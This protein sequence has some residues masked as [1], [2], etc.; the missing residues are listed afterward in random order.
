MDNDGDNDVLV[1][2]DESPSRLW[3]NDG[4]GAFTDSGQSL[5]TGRGYGDAAFSD[6]D[7][8]GDL[9]LLLASTEA[10]G[11][12][13]FNNGNMQG[14]TPGIFSDSGQRLSN[15]MDITVGDMDGDHDLDIFTCGGLWLNDGLGFFEETGMGN[16]VAGCR[17][18]WLGDIDNDGD[19]D[20]FIGS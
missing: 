16:Q 7:N 4:T 5:G 19:L 3:L 2:F 20:A 18:I 10:G 13:W 1:T 9:D 12:I 17:G 11:T 14:G 15:S 8:D 6:V